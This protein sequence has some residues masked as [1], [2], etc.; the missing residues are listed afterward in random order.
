MWPREVQ[1]TDWLTDWLKIHIE[2][3][4]FPLYKKNTEQKR[5][6]DY[7]IFQLELFE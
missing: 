6:N 4:T 2:K 1:Q 7:S 5:N 3:E